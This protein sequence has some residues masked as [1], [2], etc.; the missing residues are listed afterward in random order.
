MYPDTVFT[1]ADAKAAP[2]G[3]KSSFSTS[4]ATIPMKGAKSCDAGCIFV[5]TTEGFIP[6][7]KL[8]KVL[9]KGSYEPVT[10][11]ASKDS[12]K[13][14]YSMQKGQD[15]LIEVGPDSAIVMPKAFP[16]HLKGTFMVVFTG[17]LTSL[18]EYFG[19]ETILGSIGG[20]SGTLPVQ[21]MERP[22]WLPLGIPK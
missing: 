17:S 4:I 9:D 5:S 7:M 16:V 21:K 10:G 14:H 3:Y 2:E 1:I 6:Q 15:Y 12:A 13:F 11:I 18:Q 8:Y 20:S 22:L 19:D